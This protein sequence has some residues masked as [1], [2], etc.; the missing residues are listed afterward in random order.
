MTPLAPLTRAAVDV[1]RICESLGHRAC[2]IG[3]MAVQ[4]WICWHRSRLPGDNDAE[5]HG[6][7]ELRFQ[8]ARAQWSAARCSASDALSSD[9]PTSGSLGFVD[10][11]LED[12]I[13]D[14]ASARVA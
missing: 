10:E 13:A 2:L 9:T 8:T 5:Q 1:L 11:H 6:A 4:R 7:A 3:G 12:F 14:P